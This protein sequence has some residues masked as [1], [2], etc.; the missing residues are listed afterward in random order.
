MTSA[1]QECDGDSVVAEHLLCARMMLT[2]GIRH[3]LSLPARVTMKQVTVGVMTKR[4]DKSQRWWQF[5][6]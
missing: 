6:R 1:H 3:R 4:A 5:S 2:L